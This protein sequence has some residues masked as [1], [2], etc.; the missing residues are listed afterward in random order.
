VL[1]GPARGPGAGGDRTF[2]ERRIFHRGLA[3]RAGFEYPATDAVEN[4]SEGSL[5]G[6]AAP[7]VLCVTL[8]AAGHLSSFERTERSGDD[9]PVDLPMRRALISSV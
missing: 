1:C 3:P 7:D 2:P 6:R 5:D 8:A 4:L 9:L